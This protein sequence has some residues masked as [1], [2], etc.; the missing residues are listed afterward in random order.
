MSTVQPALA[1]QVPADETNGTLTGKSVSLLEDVGLFRMKLPRELS[2][3]EADPVTQLVVLEE[4]A[5]ANISAAWCTM[6]GATGVSLPGA[7]LPD[8]AVAEM[9]AGG[10]VPRCAT[11]GMPMGEAAAV[12]GGYRLTGRWPFASGV[13]HSEWISTSAVVKE[14]APA[15]VLKVVIR[16]DSAEL[17]D[18][19]QVVGLKGTGSCD[20]STSD[21][22]VPEAF[23]WRQTG[24]EPKWG[25]HCTGSPG[26]AMSRWNMPGLRWASRGRRLSGLSP[27]K[28]PAAAAIS[29]VCR[30][31]QHA[32]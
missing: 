5:R 7:F 29:L 1:D 22:F 24:E 31:W 15:E 8:E 2:G 23:T 11:V 21:L 18:N 17:H 19:W 9:F 13:R 16:T 26:L 14:S 28:P 10:R 6:V 20:F 3:F 25:P 32:R 30:A 4:L 27:R 12:D